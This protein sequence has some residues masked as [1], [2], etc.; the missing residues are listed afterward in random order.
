ML[1]GVPRSSEPALRGTLPENMA[2]A[3]KLVVLRIWGLMAQAAVVNMLPVALFADTELAPAS[4]VAPPELAC[5][6]GMNDAYEVP[7]GRPALFHAP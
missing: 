7:C 1:L 2:A 6:P 5:E 4:L 3:D